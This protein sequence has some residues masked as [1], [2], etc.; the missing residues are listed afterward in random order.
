[1]KSIKM[2]VK[3][4][5]GSLVFTCSPEFASLLGERKTARDE[6]LEKLKQS[7]DLCSMAFAAPEP[8]RRSFVAILDNQLRLLKTELNI[9]VKVAAQL[10]R[11][12]IAARN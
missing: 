10:I 11:E 6:M 1:M 4:R 3:G 12:Q 2:S 9:A 5:F 7:C 8:L